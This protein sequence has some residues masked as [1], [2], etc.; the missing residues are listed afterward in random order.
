MM[1]LFHCYNPQIPTEVHV[2]N[3]V[4]ETGDIKSSVRIILFRENDGTAE[5][6]MILIYVTIVKFMNMN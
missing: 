4:N 2:C 1:I 3:K 6:V 5:S